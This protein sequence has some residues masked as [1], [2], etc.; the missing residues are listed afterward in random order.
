MLKIKI[1]KQ[2]IIEWLV[3]VGIFSGIL[4]PIRFIFTTYLN[5][6]WFGAVGIITIVTLSLYYLSKK[7]K[8]GRIGIILNKKLERRSK[9]KLGLSFIIILSISI[10]IQSL[11]VVGILYADQQD[12]TIVTTVLKNNGIHDMNT[13]MNVKSQPHGLL[14][15]LEALIILLTP[16]QVSFTMMHV[17]NDLSGNFILPLFSILLVE[18]LEVLGLVMFFRYKAK[19]N[20]EPKSLM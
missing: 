6:Y 15:N 18:D 3:F 11:I 8:L 5:H 14:F 2:C 1:T 9:G 4:F 17:I 16:N 19:Y 12:V 20:K 13:A 10:Y 7:G